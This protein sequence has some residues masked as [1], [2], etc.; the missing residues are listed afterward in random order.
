M[1]TDP[2]ITDADIE[3]LRASLPRDHHA[4]QWTIDALTPSES[5]PHRQA[6]ARRECALLW[7]E[8]ALRKLAG[9]EPG[10][11]TT[12][13]GHIDEYGECLCDGEPT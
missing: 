12:C 1:P 9:A 13:K 5:H 10:C 11:C 6:N 4:Y 2:D 3:A 8:A 7:R